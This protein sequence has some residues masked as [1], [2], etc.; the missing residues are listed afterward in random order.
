MTDLTERTMKSTGRHIVTLSYVVT[1]PDSKQEIVEVISGFVVELLGIW[2]FVT[3]G[4]VLTGIK[5]LMAV[6]AKFDVWRLSDYTAG[7]D[8]RNTGIPIHFDL[9]SWLFLDKEDVGLDVAVLP[10]EDLYRK[11]LEVG[12]VVPVPDGA[13]ADEK[14]ACAYWVLVGVPNESVSYDGKTQISA[15]MVMMPLEPIDD[16][17]IPGEPKPQ[18]FYARLID[19]SEAVVRRVE[20]MSGGPIFAISKSIDN[21]EYVVIGVQS[22]WFSHQR[23]VTVFRFSEFANL[24]K[25]ALKSQ[26]AE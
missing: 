14:I 24:L 25:E 15:S 3:A 5:E 10:I 23:I 11:N 21:W 18:K 13:W 9:D 1:P 8:F 17:Q 20:G 2:F 26:M 4:H 12:N 16:T 19:G 22:G 6:G 7:G